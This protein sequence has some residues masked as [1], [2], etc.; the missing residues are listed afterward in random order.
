[1]LVRPRLRPA[2]QPRG[3]PRSTRDDRRVRPPRAFRSAPV[4]L[5]ARS[6]GSARPAHDGGVAFRIGASRRGGAL[7]EAGCVRHTHAASASARTIWVQTRASP[8]PPRWYVA[9]SARN[10]PRDRARRED[11]R[12]ATRRFIES[13]EPRDRARRE[14]ESVA[15]RRFIESSSPVSNALVHAPLD[16]ARWRGCLSK[17]EGGS[18]GVRRGRRAPARFARP[19]ASTERGDSGD[20]ENNRERR[21]GGGRL[22]ARASAAPPRAGSRA[23]SP[24]SRQCRRNGPTMVRFSIALAPS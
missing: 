1:M 9:C 17:H 4:P 13:N 7:R 5:C 18:A 20:Q 23:G 22:V 24:R 19:R 2:N 8:P 6:L 14:D 12:V 21:R 15:T 10:E 16:Q 11:K 3:P